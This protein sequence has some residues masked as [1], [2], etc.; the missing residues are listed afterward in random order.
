MQQHFKFC[1]LTTALMVLNGCVVNPA[2]CDPTNRDASIVSKA[3]CN[4]S[5]AYDERLQ[6]KQKILL[7]EQEMNKLFRD[8]YTAVE[9]EKREVSSELKSKRTEYSALT[10]ALN[11]LLNELQQKDQ[12]NSQVQAEVAALKKELENIKNQDD[13]VV[14]KKQVELD[15][16]KNR[17]MELQQGLGLR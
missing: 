3:R 14:M 5:G 7:D 12:G 16:L 15:Q 9:K 6:S 10:K 8:V 2:D 4:Y 1:V 13:P 11:A 17:V